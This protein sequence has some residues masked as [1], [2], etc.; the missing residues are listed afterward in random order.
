MTS[1]RNLGPALALTGAGIAVAAIIAGF[2]LVGGPGDARAERLDQIALDRINSAI[3][4][5]QCAYRATGKAPATIED[6]RQV[7]AKALNPTDPP[8]L[9]GGQ[10]VRDEHIGTGSEPPAPGNVVYSAMD[11]TH[12]R[13]C[14]NFRRPLKEKDRQ[15]FYFPFSEIYPDVLA[16]RPAGVHCYD[17]DLSKAAPAAEPSHEG[18]M[19]VFE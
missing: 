9:C 4:T 19:D 8:L 6:A 14:S 7:Y 1:R 17:I 16:P 2:I 15:A 3:G 11:A 5:A 10:P 18:H 13:I 12:A